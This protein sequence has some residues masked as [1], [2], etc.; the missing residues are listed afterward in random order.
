M[1]NRY[2]SCSSHT[3]LGSISTRASFFCCIF[4]MIRAERSQRFRIRV[5]KTATTLAEPLSAL[6]ISLTK[7]SIYRT[8][9]PRRTLEFGTDFGQLQSQFRHRAAQ[10]V[11]M[12][13]QFFRRL[14]LVSPVRYQHLAQILPLELAQIGRAS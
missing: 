10:R 9:A 11:A 7:R 6:A 2:A 14:A 3:K 12:H 13:S 1:S 5:S 8:F 4:C